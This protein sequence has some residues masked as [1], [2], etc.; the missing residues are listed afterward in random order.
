V[1][2]EAISRGFPTPRIVHVDTSRQYSKYP[3]Q[4]IEYVDA[5]PLRGAP[6]EMMVR[7]LGQ[8]GKELRK[9]HDRPFVRHGTKC[10]RVSSSLGWYWCAWLTHNVDRHLIL[11][12]DNGLLNSQQI[13]DCRDVFYC[14]NIADNILVSF[15]HGDLSYDNILIDSGGLKSVIDWEDAVLGDPIF[16]LAGLATFHPESRHQYFIDS[17]YEDG[18]KPKD[19]SY[20]FW[21]YYLR[22]ALAKAV[23]RHRFGYVDV[24]GEGRQAADGRIALALE[25]LKDL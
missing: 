11:V 20:R 5:K 12:R 19:F 8:L 10:G 14:P 9:L 24:G 7:V 16:E 15:L 23:H 13:S 25:R 4:I 22:I 3:F 18:E 6:E 1:N 17:Y 21:V 2:N